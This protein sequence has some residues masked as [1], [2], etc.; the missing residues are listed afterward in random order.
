MAVATN[1]IVTNR[2]RLAALAQADRM[3]SVSEFPLMAQA[4]FLLTYGADLDDLGRQSMAQVDKILKGARAA[5]LPIERPTK[6]RL[7]VNLKTA[8]ALGLS[9]PQSLLSRADDVIR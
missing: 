4:G 8:K 9:I 5:D 6:L 7:V 3:V 2:S 1:A